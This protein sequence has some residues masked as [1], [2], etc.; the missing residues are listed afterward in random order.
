MVYS[1]IPSL[2][3]SESGETCSTPMSSSNTDGIITP[4][5]VVAKKTRVLS[6][7]GSFLELFIFSN[8]HC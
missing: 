2:G 7:E 3:A 8:N 5:V 4:S 6:L 1:Q